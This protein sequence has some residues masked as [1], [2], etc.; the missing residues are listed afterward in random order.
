VRGDGAEREG[1]PIFSSIRS[2]LT[3]YRVYLGT[4]E[5]VS[6]LPLIREGIDVIQVAPCD[7]S[8]LRPMDVVLFEMPGSPRGSYILHRVVRM[9][10]GAIVTLGDN[11]VSTELVQPNWVL[12][13][14]VGL[15]RDGGEAN[16]LEAGAYRAYVALYCRPWGLR[17]RLVGAYRRM[18]H[19]GGSL[20]RRAGL[21]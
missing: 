10:D 11:C 20:L 6:M 5:G 14:L 1:A 12:G 18:R 19:L 8:R 4:A 9:G 21:R 7:L 2:V 16:A 15:Y 3:D 13:R 17:I